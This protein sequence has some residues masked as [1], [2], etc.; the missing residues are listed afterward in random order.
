MILNLCITHFVKNVFWRTWK[1]LGEK[2]DFD[3]DLLKESNKI[4]E[5]KKE[6][7]INEILA[8]VETL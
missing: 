2:K 8:S 3:Q 4:E 1:N 7:S 6:S 5:E